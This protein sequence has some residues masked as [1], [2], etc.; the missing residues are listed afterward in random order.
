MDFAD[1]A[2]TALGS[3]FGAVA[4]GRISPGEGAALATMIEAYRRAIDLAD[5]VKRMDALEAKISGSG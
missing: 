2:V 3:I 4:E 5:V 1:D